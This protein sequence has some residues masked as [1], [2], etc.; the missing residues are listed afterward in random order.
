MTFVN[1]FNIRSGIN[2]W[3]DSRLVNAA[4]DLCL[5]GRCKKHGA[6]G[7]GCSIHGKFIDLTVKELR[8]AAPVLGCIDFI[9]A[10]EKPNLLDKYFVG[11]KL[12]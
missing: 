4:T 6:Q 9:E 10:P 1:E 2:M 3:S 8:I 7:E 5:C 11:D 12:K